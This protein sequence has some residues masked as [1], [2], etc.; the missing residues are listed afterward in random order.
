MN[1]V[2]NKYHIQFQSIENYPKKV[3][4]KK[5]KDR[6]PSIFPLSRVPS[7]KRT[8]LDH[9]SLWATRRSVSNNINPSFVPS[10]K[11]SPLRIARPRCSGGHRGIFMRSIGN[12][13]EILM[14]GHEDISRS[15][16]P[17]PAHVRITTIDDN[18]YQ[19]RTRGISISP[20]PSSPLAAH[21]L[22][23]WSKARERETKG[24]LVIIARLPG[25]IT[26]KNHRSRH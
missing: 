1:K 10:F 19:P 5:K 14:T 13:H 17:L 11:R 2:S 9:A 26:V 24:R 20:P 25:R 18:N 12:L 3:H 23:V 16:P 4:L 15:R 6:I 22:G 8:T 7:V 21:I